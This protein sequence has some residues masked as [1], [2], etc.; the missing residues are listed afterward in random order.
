MEE[1]CRAE[2]ERVVEL[3]KAGTLLTHDGI[4]V[5]VFSDAFDHA[6]RTSSDWCTRKYAKDKLDRERVARVRWIVPVVSGQVPRS[7]CWSVRDKDRKKPN[8]RMYLVWDENYV[9]WLQPTDD[10]LWKFSTAYRARDAYIR[11]YTANGME[12]WRRIA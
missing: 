8:R 1:D 7:A 2:F 10:G 4:A 6:F 11:E 9:V 5:R 3:A 12:L